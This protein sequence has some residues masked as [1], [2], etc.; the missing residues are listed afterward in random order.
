[1]K[2]QYVIDALLQGR[3]SATNDILS[4]NRQIDALQERLEEARLELADGI[5]KVEQLNVAIDLLKEDGDDD[6]TKIY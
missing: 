5:S 4:I 6:V 3:A 1:M 2:H